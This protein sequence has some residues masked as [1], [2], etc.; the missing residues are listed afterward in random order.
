LTKEEK[1]FK[2]DDWD[3][4]EIKKEEESSLI[5]TLVSKLKGTKNA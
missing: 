3:E 4:T 1:R 5:K 2:K